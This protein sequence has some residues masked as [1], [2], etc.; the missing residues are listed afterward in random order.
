MLVD[1]KSNN[2]KV[3]KAPEKISNVFG[4]TDNDYDVFLNICDLYR[5][6]EYR[7]GHS[8]F[9]DMSTMQERLEERK[10]SALQIR[11]LMTHVIIRR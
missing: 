4:K 10:I 3:L 1:F 6:E 7:E 8:A 9:I 2:L 5:D 11:T